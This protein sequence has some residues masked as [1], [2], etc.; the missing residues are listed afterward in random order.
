M[1]KKEAQKQSKQ[2]IEEYAI[3]RFRGSA[4][5]DGTGDDANQH[6]SDLPQIFLFWCGHVGGLVKEKA[7]E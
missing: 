2:R 5:M 6:R 4:S 3:E 1:M 7:L